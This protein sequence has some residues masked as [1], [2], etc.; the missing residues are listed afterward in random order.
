MTDRSR[1]G[2]FGLMAFLAVMSCTSSDR[3]DGSAV[4][5]RSTEGVTAEGDAVEI[6]EELYGDRPYVRPPADDVA[7]GQAS[8]LYLAALNTDYAEFVDRDGQ[9]YQTLIGGEPVADARVFPALLG[10]PSN[11]MTYLIYRVTGI[12]SSPSDGT[13][14][15]IDID[16]IEPAVMIE[17]EAIDGHFLGPWEGTVS[18]RAEDSTCTI[19]VPCW[20][21]TTAVPLRV[22]FETLTQVEN[23]GVLGLG[24]PPLADGE[25]F[26]L[27]GTIDN[28]SGSVAASD[29]T[30][31]PSLSELG[32]AAPFRPSTEGDLT[33]WRY[34][35][36]HAEQDLEIVMDYPRDSEGLGGANGMSPLNV[37]HPAN[38][39][40]AIDR[41]EWTQISIL[42]HGTP[43]G[44]QINLA[45]VRGGGGTCG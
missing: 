42:N 14:R 6:C 4:C 10:A 35:G 30:C 8:T 44:S 24:E 28:L 27:S 29:G 2:M 31:M 9:T 11:R 17:G 36:M 15:A 41:P 16:S 12:V 18:V 23:M 25:R 43:N 33:L 3:S 20:D 39:L 21:G 7:S 40:Q 38:L 5:E 45:P 26:E 22:T 13:E 37:L 19:V 34:P 1:A 32:S